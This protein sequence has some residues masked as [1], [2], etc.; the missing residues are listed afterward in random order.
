M[1]NAF[2]RYAFALQN[3]GTL[4]G[5]R[6]GWKTDRGRVLMQYGQWD[7]RDEVPAPVY[8]Q[9]YEVWYYYSQQGGI[10]FVFSDVK[11]YG[12]YQLVHSNASGEVYDNDWEYRLKDQGQEIYQGGSQFIE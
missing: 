12:E 4:P 11:G 6:D 9:R 5:A 10:Y 7:K 1:N 8:G 2:S 3:F